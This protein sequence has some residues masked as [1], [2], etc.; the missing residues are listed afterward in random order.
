MK[1]ILFLA[2]AVAMLFAAAYAGPPYTTDDPEVIPYGSWEFYLFYQFV[3]ET[4]AAT[5]AA[6]G[7]EINYG[8]LPWLQLHMIAPLS[9]YA[10]SKGVKDI[11]FGD[12]ELGAKARFL[13]ESDIIPQAGIF[14][15]VEVPT[16]DDA[17]NLGSGKARIFIPLWLEKSWVNFSTY[18]GG[19]YW[20]EQANNRQNWWYLGWVL[21]Y[22]INPALKVG[23]E[24]NYSTAQYKEGPPL[25]SANIGLEW[26]VTDNQNLILSYGQSM[27]GD[28]TY[29]GYLGY[30]L[31]FGGLK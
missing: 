18:G 31:T 26:N 20:I 21:K 27:F 17:R 7:L 9:F 8:A 16:G 11:G 30:M 2:L 28:E 22:K 15:H 12:V 19:G 5:G 6:P 29:T 1:K 24:L 13:D 25:N 4:P 14:P 10:D 23:L 3:N